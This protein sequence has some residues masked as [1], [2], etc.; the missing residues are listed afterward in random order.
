[1]ANS[2]ETT[3]RSR[4]LLRE[5]HLFAGM[6][7][8]VGIVAGLAVVAFR[9]AIERAQHLLLG[10]HPSAL[11]LLLSPALAGVAVAVLIMLLF[12]RVRGSGVNQ[13]KAALYIY[14]GY[15]SFRTVIGKF[16]TSVLA[17]GSGH[18]LGPEDPSLQIGAGLA[19]L[20]SRRLKLSRDRA[21][22]MAPL[23]AAAGLAAAFNAPIS[24]ILFV[25]EEVIGRWS[26]GVLGAVVL[27]TVASTAVAR[28]FLGARP[29]FFGA[30]F[31]APRPAELVG[32]AVLGVF[33]GIASV[34]FLKLVLGLRPRLKAL[35]RW[36]QYCQPALAGLAIGAIALRWPEVMGAGYRSIDEAM[37][38]HFGWQR[39]AELAGWKIA[40]T[41][42]S[43]V[44]GTPGGLF[45]PTLFI[46]GMLGGAVGGLQH[47][48]LP[49]IFPQLDTSI[50]TFALI[51]MGTAF[52]GILR[53]PMTSVFMVLEVS[54]DYNVLLPLLVANTLAYLISRAFQPQP[55]FDAL[56]RQ[57]GVEL[58]SMEE[59][60]EERPLRVE[61]AM[62]PPNAIIVGEG[63]TIAEVLLRATAAEGD[64]LMVCGDSGQWSSVRQERL[65]ELAARD[66]GKTLA[67]SGALEPLPVLFPD[68]PLVAAL[69]H[70]PRCGVL[71]VVHR[72]ERERLLGVLPI[73]DALAA[74]RASS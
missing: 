33:G 50:A 10:E 17:I 37:L 35:P 57:D 61:D 4:L 60:R 51:G 53:A 27:A 24:A 7:V 45:A 44:S 59:L 65:R 23:G 64:L 2:A 31:P 18:S 13:T 16:I 43:F 28:I 73:A 63:D 71:P 58:P 41:T 20:I 69:R 55:L 54:G 74:L 32:Y 48:L 66:S 8:L 11:R 15:V 36:T 21:R 40:A 29:L 34:L 67:A 42:V 5:E 56:A 39:M 72:A 49:H 38:G 47:Q 52:A 70:E 14:D 46:G 68:Q 12:P 62:R 9:L 30:T 3:T 22:L 6:A 19:S 26:A 1:M 25:I